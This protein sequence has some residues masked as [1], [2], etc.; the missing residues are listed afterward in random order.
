MKETDMP[1]QDNLRQTTRSLITAVEAQTGKQV[2]VQDD[3][4][5]QTSATVSIARNGA[6]AHVIRYKP[7]PPDEPDYLICYQCGFILRK[8]S[9]PKDEMI[10]FASTGVGTSITKRLLSN[11]QGK[12]VR[13]D[14]D[15]LQAAAKQMEDGLLIHLLSTPIGLR[16]GTW[17]REEYP[18]IQ[19][20]QERQVLREIKV[21]EQTNTAEYKRILPKKIFETSQAINAAY[22][23]FW[24]DIL[25]QPKIAD[26][27]RDYCKDGQ[28]L[29]KILNDVSADP[30]N[31][32]ELLDKWAEYLHLSEWYQWVPFQ[33]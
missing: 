22:A 5:I 13:L 16:V 32:R 11:A 20:L 33:P 31:D 19:S 9:V 12:K 8:Y 17:L 25:Q 2:I 4:K 29:I 26:S 1:S 24:A 14:P 7:V 27:F 3:P 10:D 23:F 6:P 15:R 30:E 21:S 18:D 28:A